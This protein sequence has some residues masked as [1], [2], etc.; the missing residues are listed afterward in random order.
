[1]ERCACQGAFLDKFIQPSILMFL[2]SESL[3]G[4]SLLKKL[5]ESNTI[6]YTGL[7]P[8]GLYRTLKKMEA[9]G[10]LSSEWDTEGSAKPR[11]I[12]SITGEG[13]DCLVSWEKTLTGYLETIDNLSK[14]VSKSIKETP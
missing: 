6:D 10:L 11:R 13:K 8:T 5:E 12:Y 3:H 4:F 2:N 9:A 14:A 7:D 1:M